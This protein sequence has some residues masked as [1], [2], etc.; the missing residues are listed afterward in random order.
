VNWWTWAVSEWMWTMNAWEWEWKNILNVFRCRSCICMWCN[1]DYIFY[2]LDM[3][4]TDTVPSQSFLKAVQLTFSDVKLSY[5][6]AKA[7][8]KLCSQLYHTDGHATWMACLISYFDGLQCVKR[9][10]WQFSLS[11]LQVHFAQWCTHK[12]SNITPR[13]AV[14]RVLP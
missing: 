12:P 14:A 13:F 1:L 9:R 7:F 3:P 4:V 11:Q 8:L 5:R 2:V 6:M 10:L